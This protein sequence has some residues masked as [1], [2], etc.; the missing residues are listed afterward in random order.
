MTVSYI[1]YAKL[2]EDCQL[3]IKSLPRSA[4][5]DLA[6]VLGIPR[7]GM[8]P[9]TILANHLHLPVIDS[10]SFVRCGYQFSLTGSRVHNRPQGKT[11]LV[12]DDSIYA[13]SA[14][15]HALSVLTE[16]PPPINYVLAAIYRCPEK[17]ATV[18]YYVRNVAKPRY[19]QWNLMQHPN[20]GQFMLDMDGVIC[21]DP[22][23][24]EEDSLDFVPVLAGAPPLHLPAYPAHSICTMRLERYRGL[25]EEWLARHGVQYGKLLM[26]DAPTVQERRSRVDYG[27]WKG[28]QYRDSIA[29][30]FVE[31]DAS[32][33]IGIAYYSRKPV[34][35]LGN[36]EIYQP[37]AGRPQLGAVSR[38]ALPAE[39]L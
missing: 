4:V 23:I 5:L 20:M 6:G 35:C 15:A 19:F 14:M 11:V 37:V 33:A 12:V 31:S 16:N 36:Q 21:Y 10:Y 32:Q 26:C 29:E 38:A 24:R 3:L 22:P 9:A 18:D 25:T 27:R 17:A 1:T 34:I 7:S 30:L 8:L 13:G 28:T 39:S 2:A